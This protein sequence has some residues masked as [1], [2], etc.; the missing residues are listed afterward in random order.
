MADL[1]DIIVQGI[2]E[3]FPRGQ[4]INK[5]LKENQNKDEPP[6][7]WLE[8][9][10]KSFQLYSGLDPNNAMGQAMLRMRF[11][12]GSWEDI[13]KK[14]E[15]VEDWQDKGLDKLLREAQKVYVR[16][17]EEKFEESQK[18]QEESQKKQT[19]IL[20]AAIREGR[21][22]DRSQGQ[23]IHRGSNKRDTSKNQ[24]QVDRSGV[25]CYH[26]GKKGHIKKNCRK[27]IQE[28]RVFKED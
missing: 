8:R 14:L 20:V 2:R 19:K 9:L 12:Q 26:C 27:R 1:R 18:R 24:G 5:A 16:R 4:N 11:V 6:T 25:E 3:S 10:R 15:K 22:G 28:E 21:K 13:R 17:D 23:Q 7:E